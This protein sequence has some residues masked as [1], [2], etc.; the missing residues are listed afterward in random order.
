MGMRSYRFFSTIDQYI[1]K[2]VI[3]LI[4]SFSYIARMGHKCK[5]KNLDVKLLGPGIWVSLFEKIF[6]IRALGEHRNVEL[7]LG[8]EH[9][10]W[11]GSGA[12]CIDFGSVLHVKSYRYTIH[13]YMSL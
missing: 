5:I 4:M 11:Q 13:V 2:L 9:M 1:Y 7:G 12:L 6:L 8:R 10:T 3:V